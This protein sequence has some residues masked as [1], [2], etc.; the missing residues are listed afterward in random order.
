MMT[1]KVWL[2][3]SL[4]ISLVFNIILY[5]FSKEQSRRL[6]V[7]SENIND[8]VDIIENFKSHLASIYELESFYGDETLKFLLDHSEGL[9]QLLGEQYGDVMSLTEKIEFEFEEEENIEEKTEV[10]EKDVFYAGTRKR[11]P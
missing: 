3:V 10:Q 7:V 1:I 4:F 9:T 2:A 6:L 8:L 5:W 11:N